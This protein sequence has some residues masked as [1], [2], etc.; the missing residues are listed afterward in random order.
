MI[1]VQK[2]DEHP[3]VQLAKNYIQ[4]QDLRISGELRPQAA[5]RIISMITEDKFLK[6]ITVEQ[7]RRTKKDVSVFDILPRQLKRL[8]AGTEPTEGQTPSV[9]EYGCVLH[10]LPVQLFPSITLDTLR[11][12]AENPNLL[13]MIRGS[14]NTVFQNDLSDLGMNGVGDDGS[15]FVNLNT[16]W[17]KIAT[18][19]THTQKVT[20][21]P[22]TN[23]WIDTFATMRKNSDNRFR[24]ISTFIVSP[25]NADA[26]NIELG[27]MITGSPL[28]ADTD[29]HN[30][31][32]QKVISCRYMPDTVVMYTPIKNL[33]MGISTLIRRDSAYHARKRVLEFTYDMAVD[34]E[35]AIK[36]ACVLGTTA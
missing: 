14:F 6:Q 36:K 28:I 11:D 10:A 27:K 24:A 31:L 8:A 21:A 5:T 23:G 16:G 13:N 2:K 4:P 17:I 34:F 30:F 19:S 12:N 35:I 15:D 26:Y 25:D 1:T 18:D 3:L 7:M 32:R 33:V 29:G 20:I 9:D 22:E